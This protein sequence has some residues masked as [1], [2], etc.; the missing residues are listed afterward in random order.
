MHFK[1]FFQF[2]PVSSTS[3]GR[4]LFLPGRFKPGFNPVS[5]TRWKKPA[6]PANSQWVSHQCK[7]Q[8]FLCKSNWLGCK[9]V[10]ASMIMFW[11]CVQTPRNNSISQPPVHP[12]FARAIELIAH[13]KITQFF[14]FHGECHQKSHFSHPKNLFSHPELPFLAKSMRETFRSP[15][16][17]W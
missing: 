7:N 5:S 11:Q 13:P 10:I 6:N 14:H 9:I 4:N 15:D 12:C 17:C 8:H 3:G 2:F 1:L 16:I